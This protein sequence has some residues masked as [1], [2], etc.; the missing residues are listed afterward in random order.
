MSVREGDRSPW[1]EIQHCVEL[2][3]GAWL[4]ST[5]SHGGVKLD[6][7][8][9]REIPSIARRRGGWYEEDCDAA[10]PGF[11]LNLGKSDFAA[12]LRRWQSPELLATLGVPS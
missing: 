6:A 3:P 2:A 9:N 1:G 4:V 5:S 12:C 11:V 10:I 8:R 7:E